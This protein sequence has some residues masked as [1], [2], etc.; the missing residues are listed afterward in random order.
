M[1]GW[2]GLFYHPQPSLKLIVLKSLYVA[3]HSVNQYTLS[4]FGG[5]LYTFNLNFHIWHEVET[6]TRDKNDVIGQFGKVLSGYCLQI[7]K[8]GLV[9]NVSVYSDL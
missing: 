3:Y 7:P 4:S 1:I 8:F 6:C 5:W 2:V 9:I